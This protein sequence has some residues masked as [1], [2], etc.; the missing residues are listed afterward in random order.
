[1]SHD[2]LLR[3]LVALDPFSP[4]DAAL[5][6]VAALLAG[7]RAQLEGLVLEDVN[8]FDLTELP[9]VRVMDRATR[10]ERSLDRQRM[11]RQLRSRSDRLRKAFEEAASRLHMPGTFRVE[12]GE[13]GSALSQAARGADLLV[14]SHARQRRRRQPSSTA[15]APGLRQVAVRTVVVVR[16]AWKTGRTVAVLVEDLDRDRA[17]L[18]LAARLARAERLPLTVLVHPDADAE[19]E[20]ALSRAAGANGLEV[21]R[22]LLRVDNTEALV[23]AARGSLALVLAADNPRLDE[24]TLNRL[25]DKLPGALVLAR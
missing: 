16:E 6:A 22:H 3:A 24:A 14:V 18:D 11:E 8:L 2:D 5:D 12:R 4:S 25:L 13:V 21:R 19:V 10:S 17:A 20:A 1:V 15:A 9:F 23:A 7:R